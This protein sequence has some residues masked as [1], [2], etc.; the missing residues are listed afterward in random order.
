MKTYSSALSKLVQ[1]LEHRKRFMHK[2]SDKEN[3]TRNVIVF[4]F[5]ESDEE[6][7][8]EEVQKLL[9]QI[10]EKPVTKDCCRVGIGKLDSRRPIK[11]TLRI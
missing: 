9:K 5:E 4:G 7:L 2:V 10:E 1:L 11:F 6:A 8:D 3:R